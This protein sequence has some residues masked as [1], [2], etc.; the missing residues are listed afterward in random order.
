MAEYAMTIKNGKND[1]VFKTQSNS[2]EEAKEY[3][4]GLKQ[5]DKEDFDKIFIVIKTKKQ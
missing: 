1:I 4:R 5:M 2:L 3:F